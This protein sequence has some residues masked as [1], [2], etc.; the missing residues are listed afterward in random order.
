M[1]MH[2]QPTPGHTAMNPRMAAVTILVMSISASVLAAGKIVDQRNHEVYIGDLNEDSRADLFVRQFDVEYELEGQGDDTFETTMRSM[3]LVQR[4][5]GTFEARADLAEWQ[6]QSLKTWDKTTI[7]MISMDFNQNGLFDYLLEDVDK[8]IENLPDQLLIA[9]ENA[10]GLPSHLIPI[11]EN[12]RKIF[13]EFYA[14]SYDPDYFNQY[15]VP[16]FEKKSNAEVFRIPVTCGGAETNIDAQLKAMTADFSN[17]ASIARLVEQVATAC[18]AKLGVTAKIRYREKEITW[19]E[20]KQVGVDT[21]RF[22]R[23]AMDLLLAMRA[24]RKKWSF[25]QEDPDRL[26]IKSILERVFGIKMLEGPEQGTVEELR[27]L[28]STFGYMG[29]RYR[30]QQGAGFYQCPYEYN[31]QLVNRC[32]R[33]NTGTGE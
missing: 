3:V 24:A 13:S 22:S 26:I 5:D 33:K 20:K 2:V 6:W 12:I 23:D 15:G 10:S 19:Q 28:Y 25:E 27:G 1:V 30:F 7:E 18:V 4:S 8:Y 14:G 21:S 29:Q 32:Y 31:G 11:T 9:N 16:L 17:R